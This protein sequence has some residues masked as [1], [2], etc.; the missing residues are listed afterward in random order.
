MELSHLRTF[1]AVAEAG[2]FSRA[3]RLIASTQPTLSRQVLGLERELGRPLF[4]RL[5]KRVVLTH[6]G[7]EVLTRARRLVSE[8][9][10]LAASGHSDRGQLTGLIRLGAADSVILGRL[11]RLLQRFQNRFPGVR[12]HVKTGS[13]LEILTWV[14]EGQCD[15]GL[16]MLPGVLPGINLI[17]L[18]TDR[19]LP[20]VP[21]KH[22]LA[23]KKSVTLDEFVAERQIAIRRDTLSHQVITSVFQAG[24][25]S[26]VPDMVF[27]TFHMVL[28]FIA[29][30][31]GVG[32][33]TSL[34]IEEI[35]RKSRVTPIRLKE[36]QKASRR[37]GVALHV[38][39]IAEGPL[40][41]F[42][43]E[44]EQPS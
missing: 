35:P 21:A 2:G 19:F 28:E 14:R 24:G 31:L 36:F 32:I 17:P 7:Q 20:V 6:Y 5:G 13:S 41:A 9:D 4:D 44:V 23:Q 43:E 39:R 3:A 42:L 30:G 1:I 40:A 34:A 22:R 29:S 12:V 16:C 10:A 15:A 11:P 38:D 37:L 26:F 33:A 27:D 8:A 18:W 25:H